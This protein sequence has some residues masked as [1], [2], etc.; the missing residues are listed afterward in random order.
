MLFSLRLFFAETT[1]EKGN[2]TT[3]QENQEETRPDSVDNSWLWILLG[4]LSPLLVI[5]PIVIMFRRKISS[6]NTSPGHNVGS[7]AQEVVSPCPHYKS[8]TA[9][10]C[11]EAAKAGE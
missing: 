3:D 4:T 5:I 11:D 10:D 8:V 2:K 9:D 1:T 6:C 7:D